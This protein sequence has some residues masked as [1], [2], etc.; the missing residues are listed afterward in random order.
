VKVLAFDIATVTGVA[1]GDAGHA[2]RAW[3][4]DLGE[5]RSRAAKFSRAILMVETLVD[6]HKP[7]LIAV[8]APVGG[9]KTSHDLVGLWACVIGAA[10]KAGCK[11]VESCNIGTVRKHFLGKHLT[12]A[13]F[14]GSSKAFAKAQIKSAVMNRCAALGWVVETHDAADAAAVWDYAC[15]KHHPTHHTTTIGG[16]FT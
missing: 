1:L 8:E 11:N 13:H 15:A 10:H 9:P 2:P 5:G 7:D 3:T 12:A 4:V 16:L 6:Y 14:P